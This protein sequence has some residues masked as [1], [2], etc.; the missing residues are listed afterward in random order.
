MENIKS[1]V[2]AV[3]LAV[4]VNQIPIC[5][6]LLNCE[7][8]RLPRWGG[9]FCFMPEGV[10]MNRLID[11]APTKAYADTSLKAERLWGFFYSQMPLKK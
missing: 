5:L 1:A 10:G 7:I 6:T 11:R 3:V 2:K 4:V 8:I 9:R